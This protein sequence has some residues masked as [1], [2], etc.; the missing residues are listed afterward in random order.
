MDAV[1]ISQLGDEWAGVAVC[2]TAIT[3]EQAMIVRAH[4]PANSVVVALDGNGAGQAGAVRSLDVLSDIF[5]EVLCAQLPTEHDPR[6][7]VLGRSATAEPRIEPFSPADR[8][9]H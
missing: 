7:V 9:R 3:R 2:G 5:N 1:A 8:P 6:L 4:T